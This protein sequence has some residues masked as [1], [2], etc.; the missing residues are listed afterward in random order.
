[1]PAPDQVE[2][3]LQRGSIS[4]V[5]LAHAGIHLRVRLASFPQ[6]LL[7][8]P[9]PAHPLPAQRLAQILLGL[10]FVLH[11]AV[12]ALH[13]LSV[14]EAHYLLYALHP[15]LSYF[16]HPPMVG[17]VQW[18][19]V[20]LDLPVA[21]LRLLPGLIWLASGWLV[22]QLA[23]QFS[24]GS[25]VPADQAGLA[26]VGVFLLAP[27]FNVLAIGLL[28]DSLLLLL[29]L[30]L[31][32]QTLRLLQPL[33][34]TRP[35][36]WLLLGLLLGLAG[37]SKYTAILAAL[38]VA[39]CLLLTHGWRLLRQPWLWAATLLALLLVTPVLVWNAQHQWLSFA[40]QAQHGAG[41]GWQLRPLLVFALLQLLAYGPLL[42]WAAPGW[43]QARHG[44]ARMR[45]LFFAVPFAVL[46]WLSTGG[47]SLP[48]WTAPAW[49][50]LAPLAGIGLARAF[51]QGRRW[52]MVT[53]A[54]LQAVA[55]ALLLAAMA[56]GLQPWA[57][58]SADEAPPAN[59]FADL[60]GWDLAAERARALAQA[61]G[62]DTLAVQ[63]WTLASRL[64]WYGRPLPVQVLDHRVDQFD[65]WAAPLAAGGNALLLDWSLMPFALPVG[66]E[67]FADCRLLDNLPIRRLGGL[68]SVFRFYECRDW[69]G[70]SG[71]QA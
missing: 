35:S 23:Q 31:L 1:V 26:A 66:P 17:W 43:R 45:L 41:D 8:P 58:H 46:A 40:Y 30:A 16:D 20:A 13:G 9:M 71:E 24:Q 54:S 3:R 25:E 65:L 19:L 59:P 6:T 14:D 4:T 44:A 64:A 56:T 61:Q 53:T 37:L 27:L 36:D 22:Q 38:A 68:L 15:A 48:H 50:A 32:R 28:P 29:S 51:R 34:Q 60:H 63:H 42:L 47:S 67:G 11:A 70:T 55:L 49:A 39:L 52:L 33:P 5:I 10:G 7:R 62:L 2:G 12:G 18:P 21:V 57:E 69:Q